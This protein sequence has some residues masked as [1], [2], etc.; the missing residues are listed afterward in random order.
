MVRSIYLTLKK[1]ILNKVFL[2]FELRTGYSNN[3]II[4]A[5]CIFYYF[6]HTC[7]TFAYT[8]RR[9]KLILK[10]VPITKSKH[11][12]IKNELL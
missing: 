3:I 4:A 12:T 5:T 10:I 2:F 7:T 11:F 9:S 6:V 8:F 1:I